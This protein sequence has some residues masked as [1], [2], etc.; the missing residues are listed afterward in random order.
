MC[1]NEILV[2]DCRSRVRLGEH[3]LSTDPDCTASNGGLDPVCNESP[4]NFDI[5]EIIFHNDYGKPTVFRN[6][7]AL[8]RLNQ[9]ALYT[10]ND[11]QLIK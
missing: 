8:L 1:F 10:G 4:Q 9:S 7:I 2:L 11:C 6:D 5:E 3:R